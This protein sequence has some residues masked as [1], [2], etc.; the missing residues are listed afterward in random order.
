MRANCKNSPSPVLTKGQLWKTEQAY[1][2]VVELGKTLIHY[3]MTRN[4]NQKG[5]VTHTSAIGTFAHYLK[6]NGGRLV[7]ARPA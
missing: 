1:L 6:V 2:H 5:A 3:R 7:K 4:L